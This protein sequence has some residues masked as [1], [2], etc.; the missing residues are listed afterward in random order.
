MERDWKNY[1]IYYGRYTA[2]TKNQINI[3]QIR[4]GIYR[5]QRYGMLNKEICPTPVKY[6]KY[7]KYTQN[8]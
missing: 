7:N 6:N 2:N 1:S 5:T 3:N 4:K 8:I